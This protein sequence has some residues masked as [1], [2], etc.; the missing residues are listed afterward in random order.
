MPDNLS[1]NPTSP[2]RIRG[3]DIIR[4]VSFYAILVFHLSYAFWARDHFSIVAVKSWWLV[5]FEVYARLLVFGGFT[6]LFLSFFLF[7]LKPS[8]SGKW[9]YLWLLLLLFLVVWNFTTE[10]LIDTWDIYP[11][12]IASV[13]AVGLV[14][15]LKIPAAV[16]AFCGFIIVSIP[17]WLFEG[18]FNLPAEL[19]VA[20]WGRCQDSANMA[21]W[22]LLPWIGYPLLAF[23]VGNLVRRCRHE[24]NN[25]AP[26]ERW[27]WMVALLG[28]LPFLGNYYVTPLGMDFGCYVFRRPVLEF[29]AHQIWIWFMVRASLTGGVQGW[30]ENQPWAHWISARQVNRRF[31]LVYF[32]HYPLVFL[33]GELAHE[34]GLAYWAAA[35]VT[36]Y[37]S[38]VLLLEGLPVVIGRIFVKIKA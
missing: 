13:L 16:V 29:W 38:M 11:F 21:D 25:W 18:F 34:L 5:P 24:F 14:R 30:L 19:E 10:E 4:L 32:A 27:V 17:F 6:I 12:L 22:P 3:I 31:F 7:G 2:G 15:W 9:K 33:F 36:A 37:L 8:V 23:A 26:G 1:P 28:S 20:L 35:Y